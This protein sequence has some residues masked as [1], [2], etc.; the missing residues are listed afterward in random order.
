M[1]HTFRT[2]NVVFSHNPLYLKTVPLIGDIV[3]R[4]T[5]QF[6][7]QYPGAY[8][9]QFSNSVKRGGQNYFHT[10]PEHLTMQCFTS[11]KPP[12]IVVPVCFGLFGYNLGKTMF[13]HKVILKNI[14]L[15]NLPFCASKRMII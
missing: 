12:Y 9:A 5:C 7:G 15:Q 3:N 11:L 6:F 13:L 8:I 2:V 10:F 4:N 1:V 14:R